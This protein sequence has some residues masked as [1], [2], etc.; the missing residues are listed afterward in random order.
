MWKTRESSLPFLAVSPADALV[1][2]PRLQPFKY[3][4][5]LLSGNT[6]CREPSCW[7]GQEARG[8]G[9]GFDSSATTHKHTHTPT[10][11]HNN[12]ATKWRA[13][14]LQLRVGRDR[15]Q[16]DERVF[17]FRECHLRR[18][19][20]EQH[21]QTGSGRL[22]SKTESGS[23]GLDVLRLQ[24]RAQLHAAQAVQEDE[25]ALHLLLNPTVHGQNSAF[26]L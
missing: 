6:L 12:T 15:D 3:F 13:C 11:Q 4:L 25:D 24:R 19:P 17:N 18:R 22:H 14:V 23:H 1:E 2:L 7:G 21:G 20:R 26:L 10:Y 5:A 8:V 16:V 9:D